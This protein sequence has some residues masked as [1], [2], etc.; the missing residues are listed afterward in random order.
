MALMMVIKGIPYYDFF[1]F[2][3]ISIKKLIVFAV[4]RL[5]EKIVILFWKN[6]H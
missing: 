2:F 4:L 3:N 5:Y 6:L 1:F